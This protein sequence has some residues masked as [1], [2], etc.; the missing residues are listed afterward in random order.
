MLVEDILD[1]AKVGP[2]NN[3]LV[4]QHDNIIIKFI[5]LGISELYR[6]FNMSIKVETILTNPLLALYELRNPDVSLFL[7][8]HDSSHKELRQSDVLGSNQVDYK[9]INFRSFLLNTPKDELLYA[10]YKASP[11]KVVDIKDV[12]DLPDSMIDA[13]LMYVA[14]MGHSTINKDN[15]NEAS[16]YNKRFEYACAN[17]DN[18]GYRIPL[19]T[20]SISIALKGYK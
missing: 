8:L 9:V 10:V 20:E 1:I 12:I 6:R 11:S 15:T 4:A 7:S 2:L 17:L 13:L 3:L 19:N 16:T 5:D 18:Q 14:Y